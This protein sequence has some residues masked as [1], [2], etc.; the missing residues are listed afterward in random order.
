MKF[1]KGKVAAMLGVASVTVLAALG[2]GK[3]SVQAAFDAKHYNY[4][5][6]QGNTVGTWDGTHYYD[7]DGNMVKNAF[8]CDGTYT[9]F[10]QND[11]TPMKDRLTYHPDGE[12]I[13]YFDEKG[14]EVFSNFANVKQSIAGE[15]VDDLCFFDVYGYM[16]VDTRTYDQSGTKLYYVNEYGII[17]R[18]KWIQFSASYNK[19]YGY[20]NADGSLMTSQ[21]TYNQFGQAVYIQ[22]DGTVATGWLYDG[23]KYYRLDDND[24]HLLGVYDQIPQ[25][26]TY[27]KTVYNTDGS[28]TVTTY[29]ANDDAVSWFDYAP[30]GSTTACGFL[31]YTADGR[32]VSEEVY[33]DNGTSYKTV[34]S[35]DGSGRLSGTTTTDET[36]AVTYQAAY[37]C[38]ANADGSY[39]VETTDSEGAKHTIAYTA[40]NKIV[41]ETIYFENG[42]STYTMFNANGDVTYHVYNDLRKDG[43]LLRDE[44]TNTYD[45]AGNL[46]Q[47]VYTSTEG[48]TETTTYANDKVAT[49]TAKYADGSSYEK[50]CNSNG[51]PV[52]SKSIDEY[53]NVDT[54]TAYQYDIK[55][56]LTEKT[57]TYSDGTTEKNIFYYNSKNF[58]T[59]SIFI[60][61][62]GRK[63]I[64][65]YKLDDRGNALEEVETSSNGTITTYQS[66]YDAKDRVT[67]QTTYNYDGTVDVDEYTYD[68]RGNRIK[69]VYNDNGSITTIE[70][71]YDKDDRL[72]K[73]TTTGADGIV[74]TYECTYDEDGRTLKT[75]SL[76]SK[77]TGMT[78]EYTYDTDGNQ[79]KTVATD[80]YGQVHYVDD[81]EY[82]GNGDIIKRTYESKE[83]SSY[84]NTYGAWVSSPYKTIYEYANGYV[85]KL[86]EYDKDG[87]E[88][89]TTLYERDTYGNLLKRT[90]TD[91]EGS[92]TVYRYEYNGKGQRIKTVKEGEDG[93]TETYEYD[94]KGREIKEVQTVG[95]TVAF[96]NEY[97]YDTKGN[98]IKST[99]TEDGEVSTTE[100]HRNSYG[101]T[102]E[103]IDTCGDV[104]EVT[105]YERDSY[106][107]ITKKVNPSGTVNTYEYNDKGYETKYS[108]TYADGSSH[109]YEYAKGHTVKSEYTYVNGSIKST[110]YVYEN[111]NLIKETELQDGKENRV[112]EYT[113][114]TKGNRVKEVHT[115]DAGRQNVYEYVYEYEY[116][117]NNNEVKETQTYMDGSKF[118][119][120]YTY[121]DKGQIT[122]KVETESDCTTTTDITYD[123]K[124][125]M[126]SQVQFDQYKDGY[127][128]KY[129]SVYNEDGQCI[130]NTTT[131]TDKGGSITTTYGYEYDALDRMTKETIIYNEGGQSI[132]EYRYEGDDKNHS[133]Y[134]ATWKEKDGSYT[135]MVFDKY[136]HQLSYKAY[137]KDGN[138]V[139]EES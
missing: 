13:I 55:G 108:Y 57:W 48:D 76:S 35:Y 67:K 54:Q 17:E 79:I 7:A 44:T 119:Y 106:G 60:N 68:N 28:S 25:D 63:S 46:T 6:A 20:A 58:M 51:D 62:S 117:K 65:E 4:L 121:N 126:A 70:R 90:Q 71:A 118:T 19:A 137:D 124:G 2:A 9:Y 89:G 135:V 123:K 131:Y 114:D 41:T 52:S 95:D 29:N 109:T 98:L 64:T 22:G 99:H 61:T 78:Y 24:G 21:W 40:D 85:T 86:V 103:E 134:T 128:W 88:T 26:S 37:T 53:G 133:G 73:R 81:S 72:I 111:D 12:H 83:Y 129:E 3:M 102:M 39:T 96:T 66:E 132:C 43:S 34:N 5:D 50:I 84:N 69:T 32:L 105:T 115:Y 92:Q 14:H 104:R 33:Y 101:E 45:A 30:D 87:K 107:R 10:L 16:Y 97:V 80:S 93:Y 112:S 1:F 49:F 36:G 27:T 122:K 82:A 91:A 120:E 139:Y 23:A 59:K 94:D 136:N 127:S 31:T 125:R 11:G 110:Q 47:S 74:E 18:N 100:Y 113:Y 77:G 38:T 56:N 8:F 75:T 130:K 42:D 15:P 116:D 138:L